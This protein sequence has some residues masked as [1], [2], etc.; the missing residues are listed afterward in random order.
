V[1]DRT[2]HRGPHG[3]AQ[4][5]ALDPTLTGADTTVAW[6]LLTGHWHPAWSQFLISVIHLRD[7]P[8]S[9]DAK[10]HFPG[11]THELL[12]CALNPGDPPKVHDATTLETGGLKAVGGWL[13]PVDVVHQFTATDEEMTELADLCAE[14]CVNGQLTPSTDDNRTAYREA[15]LSA[16]VRTLAHLRGEEHAP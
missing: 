5:L 16:C 6:W 7:V 3:T 9:P 1:T 14:A 13:D 4:R 12:V 10:L 15:W 8:G 2:E 11:A